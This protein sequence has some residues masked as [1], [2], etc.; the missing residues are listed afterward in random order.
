MP[1]D[2]TSRARLKPSGRAAVLVLMVSFEQHKNRRQFPRIK[3]PIY[4]KNTRLFSPKIPVVDIGLGG[5]RVYSDE[6]FRVGE[7]V[8]IELYLPSNQTLQCTVRVVWLAL[9]GEDAP[10]EFDIGL[11]I[12]EVKGNKLHLLAQI[13]DRQDSGGRP[14]MPPAA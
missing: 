13:L 7:V 2:R 3:A 8:D 5:M 9:L 11:Q 4:F 12:V 14:S 10:A 6:A 1:R